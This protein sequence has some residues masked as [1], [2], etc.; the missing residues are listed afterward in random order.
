[1]SKTCS[2]W[3]KFLLSLILRWP[4]LALLGFYQDWVQLY[5]TQCYFVTLLCWVKYDVND[6]KHYFTS[7]L[8]GPSW[9]LGRLSM[10]EY[11]WV[12]L[13]NLVW[14]QNLQFFL[15]KSAF[16]SSIKRFCEGFSH[17]APISWVLLKRHFWVEPSLDFPP[18]HC[19][20]LRGELKASHVTS[21]NYLET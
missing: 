13:S 8:G 14:P 12:W 2:N 9:V 4:F 18:V 21:R 19:Y 10:V 7:F 16:S 5:W 1:M 3:Q 17:R 6:R 15:Q 20:W 11:G